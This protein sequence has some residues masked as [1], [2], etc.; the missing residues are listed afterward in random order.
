MTVNDG[1][2][3]LDKQQSSR[4]ST[5]Q[6]GAGATSQA[7]QQSSRTSGNGEQSQGDVE[8]LKAEN[9]SLKAEVQRQKEFE[10]GTQSKLQKLA[11]IEK[12]EAEKATQKIPDE[13][14]EIDS[15][16]VELDRAIEAHKSN[17][18]EAGNPMP[19]YH[20]HL[21]IQKNNLIREKQR[22]SKDREKQ[23]Y[24]SQFDEVLQGIPASER[25]QAA[26]GISDVIMEFAEN[27]ETLSPR[28]ALR[29]FNERS[30][31]Q[32]KIKAS[33]TTAESSKL[34]AKAGGQQGLPAKAAGEP[35]EGEKER[36][37]LFGV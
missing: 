15:Q 3:D 4:A 9:E 30:E 13:V 34:G 17:R 12:A 33:E 37:R 23:A 25:K 31:M 36:K 28:A 26:S 29:I 20:K 27:G 5:A 35:S 14:A 10:R 11:A 8:K 32:A 19:I 18:D 1:K 21:E 6:S 7:S 2:G 22:V 16:I 24:A